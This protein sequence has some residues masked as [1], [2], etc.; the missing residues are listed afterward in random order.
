MTEATDRYFNDYLYLSV[1]FIF[2]K[3][4]LNDMSFLAQ[5]KLL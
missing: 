3:V 4:F 1:E 2:M 5:V